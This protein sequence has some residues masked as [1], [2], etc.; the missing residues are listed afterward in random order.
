M[1]AAQNRKLA[2]YFASQDDAEIAK[3]VALCRNAL[4]EAAGIKVA[5]AELLGVDRRSLFRWIRLYPEITR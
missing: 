5:A 2:A 3:G 4:K 1:P